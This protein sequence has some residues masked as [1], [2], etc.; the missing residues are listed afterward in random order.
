MRFKKQ[1]N[2]IQL[3]KLLTQIC[4]NTTKSELKWLRVW[5]IIIKLV[6]KIKAEQIYLL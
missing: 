5:H 1:K 2:V 6:L 3:F 4:A